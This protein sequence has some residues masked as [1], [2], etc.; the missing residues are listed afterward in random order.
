M[1]PELK[2]ALIRVTGEYLDKINNAR[3]D[4]I[5]GMIVWGD[6]LSEGKRMS[7]EVFVAQV[8]K[9]RITWKDSP[10]S[11]PL[12]NLDL[13]SIRLSGSDA[14]VQ[15]KKYQVSNSPIIEIKLRWNGQ[16][17]LVFDDNIFGYDRLMEKMIRQKN[18]AIS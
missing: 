12:V 18:S 10:D 14:I 16:G 4:E 11:H 13:E 2:I 15:L 7:K 9:S 3:F 8:A 17:W 1:S 5:Q 6:Y